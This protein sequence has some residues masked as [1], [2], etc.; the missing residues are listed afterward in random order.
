MHGRT[1]PR[2]TSTATPGFPWPRSAPTPGRR[3]PPRG[4]GFATTSGPLRKLPAFEGARLKL[5]RDWPY[6]RRM[7]PS[8]KSGGVF[9]AFCAALA[10]AATSG[11]GKG[12]AEAPP[13]AD[14]Q[15]VTV[16]QRDVPIVRDWVGSLDGF[17]NAQIRA[18]VSGCLTRQVYRE[19]TQVKQGD[20]LFE[21]DPRPF[22]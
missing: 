3:H 18:Q 9:V 1:P 15:V 21:I 11:C 16:E 20:V 8:Y 19:G 17:V 5:A 6:C 7:D 14:V 10:V 4:I 22:E 12:T 13:P 2:R